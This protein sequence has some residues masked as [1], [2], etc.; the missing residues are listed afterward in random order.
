MTGIPEA[1]C[2]SV[3]IVADCIPDVERHNSVNVILECLRLIPNGWVSLIAHGNDLVYAPVRH[4]LR[5]KPSIIG[6]SDLHAGYAC[7]H[8]N[9]ATG[10]LTWPER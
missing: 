9:H 6:R 3:P 2:D 5:S 4:L 10:Y 7:S 1:S 8:G